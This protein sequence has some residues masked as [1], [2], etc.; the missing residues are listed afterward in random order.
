[1]NWPQRISPIG[2]ELTP[3]RIRAA[4]LRRTS[5]GWQLLDRFELSRP[6]EGPVCSADDA[7]RLA[8]TLRRRRFVGS[9]VVLSLPNRELIRGLLEVT[10]EKGGDPLRAAAK[11]VE[12][13]HR[14]E[15]G[16]YELAA[17]LPPASGNRRQT[18]V[19]V[20]G[21]AHAVSLPLL[22]AFD[23]AGLYVAA[24]DSRACA[25]TRAIDTE[26]RDGRHLTAVLD[27]EHPAGELMLL[28]QGSVVYQRPLI[29]AGLDQAL[30]RLQEFGLEPDA[31]A[32]ALREYGMSDLET[33]VGKKVRDT[34]SHFVSGLIQEARP[35]IDYAARVYSDLPIRR[36]ALVGEAAAVP[37]L[38]FE[39][40]QQL[41]L[42][43]ATTQPNQIV[44][45]DPAPAYAVALGLTLHPEEA[46]WA[47][48]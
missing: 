36:F 45:V 40:C 44:N 43:A 6:T 39:I 46:T 11:D 18:A 24:I 9:D 47:A 3:G 30:R 14:L 33:P 13:T 28:H 15:P 10:H 34:L 25:L 16:N 35:A 48:A 1:M 42:D 26:T 41:R 23:A 8:S 12:R 31:A 21:V 22:E 19:C 5:S 27:I 29:D 32:L 38:G 2:V 4:Q 7:L 37:L 17:W 20:S